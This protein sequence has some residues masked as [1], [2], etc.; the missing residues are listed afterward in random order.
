MAARQGIEVTA[1]VP[2]G[3]EGVLTEPALDLELSDQE[4]EALS[5]G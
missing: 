2:A 5:H 1:A 4:F 3:L